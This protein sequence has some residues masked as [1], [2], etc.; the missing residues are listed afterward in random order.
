MVSFSPCDLYIPFLC[1]VQ[2]APPKLAYPCS[3]DDHHV[4]GVPPQLLREVRPEHEHIAVRNV[5]DVLG[6]FRGTFR[7]TL[8]GWIDPKLTTNSTKCPTN[9]VRKH[10]PTR[11]RRRR[12][13]YST[14]KKKASNTCPEHRCLRLWRVFSHMEKDAP[15]TTTLWGSLSALFYCVVE[16]HLSYQ[17]RHRSTRALLYKSFH[18]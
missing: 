5:Q 14:N 6:L 3:A 8:Q 2:K 4:R 1:A 13:H 11:R 7:G 9:L 10:P 16:L 18:S 12:R 15:E 17:V